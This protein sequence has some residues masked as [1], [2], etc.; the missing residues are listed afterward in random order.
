MSPVPGTEGANVSTGSFDTAV[1]A[2][3]K[4]LE[5]YMTGDPGPVTETFSRRE[6][7]TLANPLGPPQR[8]PANVDAAIAHG[9]AQ[10]HGGSV[11]GFEEISRYTTSELGYIVQIE[12]T[13]A[14]LPGDQDISPIALRVTMIFRPEEGGWK[15]V[16]RHADPITSARDVRTAIET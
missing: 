2:F 3:R 12:R 15:I 14:V 13:Q 11:R 5:P 7:V 1:E 10:L 4:A 9:A 6:D 16:H 8:G